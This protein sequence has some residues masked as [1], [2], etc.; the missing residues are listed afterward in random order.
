MKKPTIT[1]P[2]DIYDTLELSALAFGGIGAGTFTSLDDA[3]LV[4]F[5]ALGHLGSG[6]SIGY[7][8]DYRAARVALREAFG[9]AGY[10]VTMANDAA[11]REINLRK[12]NPTAVRVTFEEWCEEL[13]VVR[14]CAE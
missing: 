2:A 4:P 12:G 13:N 6:T 9:E 7:E 1:I 14:G 8:H 5:C 10:T 3:G 11:V